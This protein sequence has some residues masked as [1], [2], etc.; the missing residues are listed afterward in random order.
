MENNNI[1][2]SI[3]YNNSLKE[4]KEIN[5]DLIKSYIISLPKKIETLA[6]FYN[7]AVNIFTEYISITQIYS[8]K[9]KELAIN[10]QLNEEDEQFSS[11][12]QLF[13]IIRTI[14]FFNSESLNE[15]I[16]D[17]KKEM[18][19]ITKE[20]LTKT[21]D[22]LD[23]LSKAY[24]LDI[25]KVFLN[26]KKYE[27]EMKNYEELLINQEIKK[28][29]KKESSKNINDRNEIKITDSQE[30]YFNSVKESNDIL[31]KII[32]ISSEA[33]RKIREKIN[34][35]C[36]FILDT[37]IF[38]TKKQNEN[39]EL[40]KLNLTE[41]YSSNIHTLKEEEELNN[42]LI[43][44][45]PY[46]LMCLDIYN[47]KKEKKLKRFSE[48]KVK[49]LKFPKIINSHSEDDNKIKNKILKL[50]RDNILRIV[51]TLSKNKIILSRK[52]EIIQKKEIEKKLIKE[53]L[54]F[55]FK[56]QKKYNNERK[57][58]LF[59]LLEEDKENIM[60]FFKIL[61]NKR[62][63]D[64]TILNKDTFY[65]LGETF[66][67]ITKISIKEKDVKIF[68]FLIILSVTYYYEENNEKKYLFIYID[69]FPEF[70][71]KEYWE[72]YFENFLN[73]EIENTLN[74]Y[75]SVK[76]NNNSNEE[77]KKEID[78]KIKLSLFSSL[79]MVIQNMND[80]H[81]NK[82]I[83]KE[84]VEKINEHYKL[85]EEELLQI[86]IYL[87]ENNNV[88][89]ENTIEEKNLIKDKENKININDDEES[90][91]NNIINNINSI[92][93]NKDNYNI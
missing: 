4:K 74:I 23:N 90:N 86:N 36:N 67:Y 82:K 46:S 52:D 63:K 14:L 73:N 6:N 42:N 56:E 75:G 33:K 18:I 81:L 79:L 37:L 31:Q 58:L 65:F 12:K 40:Q 20:S 80:F 10:I 25:N 66:E 87:N 62:G 3:S 92:N 60:Y 24:L 13:N 77:I 57:N 88:V 64:K 1:H 28:I 9:L 35:K 34:N 29:N 11:E 93:S 27:K 72:N 48:K 70:Q 53:I 15:I 78:D 83:I 2:K 26:Q 84:F 49:K 50:K 17:L 51:E 32:N 21:N 44:P 41:T 68:K 8:N 43:P 59:K 5:I 61:N 39:Y 71:E 85:S 76:G 91:E 7:K 89:D 54:F 55:I 22:S 16:N 38:F 45:M 30:N 19:T 47:K 69:K